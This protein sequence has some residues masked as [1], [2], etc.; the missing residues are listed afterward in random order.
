VSRKRPILTCDFLRVDL[1]D[2]FPKHRV[3]F[4][5]G[6]PTPKAATADFDLGVIDDQVGY[7][8][9][10]VFFGFAFFHKN[11]FDLRYL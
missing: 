6:L 2:Q 8:P 4:L 3:G 10:V 7:L 9:N 11:S 5:F 1:L